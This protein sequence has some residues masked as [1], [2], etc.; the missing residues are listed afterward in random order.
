MTRREDRFDFDLPPELIAQR[1]AARRTASRL[2]LVDRGAGRAGEKPFTELD[3]LLRPGDLLVVN[4]SRVLPARLRLRRR[5]GGGAVEVLL[6]RPDGPRGWVVMARPGRRLRPG[7]VLET[8]AG[9]PAVEIAGRLPGGYFLAR[10]AVGDLAAVAEAHGE[11]PLPP[12]I[13]RDP[14]MVTAEVAA[15]DRERYQTVYARD[16]GSVAAPTAGLH[17]DADLLRRLSERGV[18]TARVTLHVGPGTFRPPDEEDL[19]RGRLH[20]E[21]FRYPAEVD[22][23]LRETRAAG[24]RVIAVGTTSLRVLETV[25]RLDLESAGPDVRGWEPAPED[26][27]PVFT[28]SA[29]R[30]EA[31]WRVEGMTRLFVRPPQ[32]VPAADGLLTNFHLPGSSLL[33]LVAAFAGPG[34]WPGVYAHAVESRFRFYSYGDAMFIRPAG[35]A[36]EGGEG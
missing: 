32:E 8:A 26:P 21:V 5:P 13:R 19:R 2:L 23:E 18:R 1:P 4:D 34:V 31:G 27:D 30:E 22:R 36:D 33:M 16:T 10:A 15:L 28:G 12:Y 29:V 35:G 14:G 9:D 7:S 6:V 20:A 25:R 17:F 24:G 3:S 11:T